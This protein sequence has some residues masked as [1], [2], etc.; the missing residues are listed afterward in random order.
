MM[1]KADLGGQVKRWVLLL[2]LGGLLS[3][4]SPGLEQARKLYDL[5]NFDQSLKILKAIPAKNAPVFA[6]MGQNYYMQADYSKAT[7]SLSKALAAEPS[8]SDYAMWLARAYGRRAETS[9]PFTAPVHA[10]KARQYFEKAVALNP[11]NLEAM[12]DLFEYYLEAPGFLGGGFD[13]AQ[14]LAG[15]IASI[16]Q[17]EGYWA[18]AKLAEKR[19][20]YN[21]A[22]EQLRHAIQAA[23][24]QVGRVID[25]A[26]FLARQGRFQEADQSFARAE[27]MAPN[28]PSVMFAKADVYIK[29]G[30]NLEVARDLLKRYL[31][32]TLT[33]DDPPRA[34]AERLLRQVR[35]S[36][37]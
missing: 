1:V 37:S 26:R 24:Q 22:E 9:S 30:R 23:P 11:R 17:A 35:G 7:D 20:E 2:C 10:S 21:S 28:S 12:N 6:L 3:A 34:D 36:G 27:Q 8:N 13:K 29:N 14:A 25:L 33:P 5:T 16:D 4:Q 19:K 32:C 31:N 18:R 15:Q